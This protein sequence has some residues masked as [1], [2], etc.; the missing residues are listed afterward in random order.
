MIW[1]R[2]LRCDHNALVP[3]VSFTLPLRCE[4]LLMRKQCP[5]TICIFYIMKS[6]LRCEH[7][8]MWTQLCPGTI[9]IFYIMNIPLRCEHLIMWTQCPSTICIFY[10]MKIPLRCEHSVLE[11]FVSY[12]LWKDLWDVPPPPPHHPYFEHCFPGPNVFMSPRFHYIICVSDDFGY[13][14]E[15]LSDPK[16]NVIQMFHFGTGCEH[17]PYVHCASMSANLNCRYIVRP[18]PAGKEIRGEMQDTQDTHKLSP[19]WNIQLE[20]WRDLN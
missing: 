8:L 17:K 11:P 3:F 1:Q 2:P 16:P 4:R 9:C 19:M 18:V 6:P 13:L 12:T 14:G 5:G 15:N 20:S 7:L 10:I